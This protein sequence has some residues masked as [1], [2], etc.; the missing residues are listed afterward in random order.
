ME[1]FLLHCESPRGAAV[2]SDRNPFR[3]RGHYLDLKS[4]W[5]TLLEELVQVLKPF[6]QATVSG[7][8][9]I[10]VCCT[11]TGKGPPEVHTE[12][13]L[14]VCS[15]QLFPNSCGTGDSFKTTFKEDGQNV[16]LLLPLTPGCSCH[17]M[18]S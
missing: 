5:W 9:Y 12:N 14:R 3:P 1:Q 6:D 8:A 7:E 13:I 15:C 11:S 10:T 18:I 16:S 4:D 2:A 17:Q